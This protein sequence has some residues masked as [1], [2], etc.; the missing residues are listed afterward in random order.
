MAFDWSRVWVVVPTRSG[1][2]AD[3]ANA[4][5]EMRDR[6]PGLPPVYQFRNRQSTPAGRNTLVRKFLEEHPKADYLLS[7]DDDIFPHP[8]L[9]GLATR[10]VDIVAAPVL[11]VRREQTVPFPNV[12]ERVGGGTGMHRPWPNTFR[13]WAQ[14]AFIEV[15]AVGSG[16]ICIHRRVLEH[17]ELR[18][19]FRYRLDEFGRIQATED[20]TFCDRAKALGFKVWADYSRRSDQLVNTAIGQ[21]AEKYAHAFTEP[22]QREPTLT[23]S[24]IWIPS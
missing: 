16:A 9:F 5:A 4:L 8:D 15:D 6:C 18:E 23:P 11:I 7:I 24:G 22:L 1:A 19:A 12:Y 17:P 2:E 3:L 10:E 13:L 21:L 20:I 14:G